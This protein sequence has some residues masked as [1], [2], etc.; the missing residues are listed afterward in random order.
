MLPA[1]LISYRRRSWHYFLFDFCYY[2][3]I[4]NF[5]F[6][7]IAPGSPALFVA[8]YCLSHGSLAMA[9]PLWRNSLVF[10]D[11]D[12]VCQFSPSMY[13]ALI[14]FSGHLPVD[15]HLSATRFHH[16]STLLPWGGS[17][18]PSVKATTSDAASPG[19]GLHLC[20]LLALAR[21]AFP[22]PISPFRSYVLHSSLLEVRL[23][24]QEEESRKWGTHD[25]FI[26]AARGSTRWNWQS[27]IISCSRA[28]TSV[29]HA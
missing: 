22:I 12:K 15:P 3:N 19:S 14:P 9:V 13:L 24:R 20:N 29:L 6:L 16:H 7:W 10:H 21:S 1:R 4:L 5:I 18:I 28:P 27:S 8:C 25:L 2:V 23:C 26:L 11:A 17:T